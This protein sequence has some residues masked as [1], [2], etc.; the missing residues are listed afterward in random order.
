[1]EGQILPQMSI[2]KMDQK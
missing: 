2:S 1:L